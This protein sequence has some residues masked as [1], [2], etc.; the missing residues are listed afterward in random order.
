MALRE[1]TKEHIRLL[2]HRKEDG[3]ERIDLIYS[4]LSFF[5]DISCNQKSYAPI[6]VAQ[7]DL[8]DVNKFFKAPRAHQ[9]NLCPFQIYLFSL[10]PHTSTPW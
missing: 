2:Q 9:P 8:Q 3:G 1:D 4:L 5:E 7:D 6:I 10:D